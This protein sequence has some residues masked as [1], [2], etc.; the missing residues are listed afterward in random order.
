MT[1]LCCGWS[2]GVIE[3]EWGM[4]N[5]KGDDELQWK[6]RKELGIENRRMTNRM[7]LV[8]LD[9]DV[10]GNGRCHWLCLASH[11][12]QTFSK[13]GTAFGKVPGLQGGFNAY[14]ALWEDLVHGYYSSLLFS[15]R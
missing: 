14:P 12:L 15:K 7:V 3:T 2:R 6:W 8:S 4:T 1:G 9:G 5:E 13:G 10:K 11:R